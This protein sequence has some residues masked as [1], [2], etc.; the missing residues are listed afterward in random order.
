MRVA[1]HWA[2]LGSRQAETHCCSANTANPVSSLE[3]S[4][5][6]APG[7]ELTGGCRD[8]PQPACDRALLPV[9]PH[10]KLRHHLWPS[11]ILTTTP[12]LL[13]PGSRAH[14]P[15]SLR[16]DPAI[17]VFASLWRTPTGTIASGPDSGAR[18]NPNR[19]ES[20][21]ITSPRPLD[22]STPGNPDPSIF[23]DK[24]PGYPIPNTRPRR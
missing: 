2:E 14:Q 7:M 1:G 3:R 18:P 20:Q 17:S 5:R 8:N 11:R 24:Q 6:H 21:R 15:A 9:L 10:P 4:S 19:S 22:P 12:P 23:P 13:L 16:Q